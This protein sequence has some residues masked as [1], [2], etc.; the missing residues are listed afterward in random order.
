MLAQLAGTAGT[1]VFASVREPLAARLAGDLAPAC[2]R[3]VGGRYPLARGA[4]EEMTREDFART[5][6]V[7][8]LL[9]AF[10]QQRLAPYVDTSA[11]AWAWRR[12]GG[13]RAAGD[14]DALPQFQRAQRIREAYFGD[15]GR[16]FGT[17]LEFRLLAMDP[18]VTELALDIDGQPLRFRP[19]AREPR[20][21]QWPGPAETGRVRVQIA[22]S[23][24]SGY[25]FE[26]PWALFR[27][28]DRVRMEPGGAP[29][30]VVLLLD[31]E[32]RKARLEVRSATPFH[33]M[34]REELEQFQC[35]RRL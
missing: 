19:G 23:S 27:L 14:G 18:G 21:V 12:E 7:G 1:Q 20:S 10:F 24:G 29:D 2:T 31:V 15:G 16:R 28:L 30:R 13:A 34:L 8:G 17:R 32:G 5:F 26:G 25:V 33:P 6:G 35:P 4:A 9:D 11:R 22:P 3:A